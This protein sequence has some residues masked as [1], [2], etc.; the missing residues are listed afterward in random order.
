MTDQTDQ[1]SKNPT[2][3]AGNATK[4]AEANS[5]APADSQ[6]SVS[7]RSAK[8]GPKG[9][10]R[11]NAAWKRRSKDSEKSRARKQRERLARAMVQAI[12]PTKA[13]AVVRSMLRIIDRADRKNADGSDRKEAVA[14]F[15]A[16]FDI[17]GVKP[18]AEPADSG[19]PQTFVFVLPDRGEIPE[20][21]ALEA[22][23]VDNE[24]SETLPVL[25]EMPADVRG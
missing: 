19:R 25:V 16:L 9:F 18:L 11:G 15:K 22:R 4:A 12:T 8:A 5:G 7:T 20:A 10:Q 6:S 23:R 24:A 21:R 1:T 13:R 3:A 17:L 2:Q 14:A